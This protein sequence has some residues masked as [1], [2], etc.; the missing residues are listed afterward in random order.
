MSLSKLFKDVIKELPR[1]TVL[2]ERLMLA[3]E[4]YTALELR[5]AMQE[6]ELALSTSRINELEFE[7]SGLHLKLQEA[8]EMIRGLEAELAAVNSGN[9]SVYVC[10]HCGS[11]RLKRVGNRPHPTFGD[12][13][14][15][16]AVFSCTVCGK[17][18]AFTQ[19]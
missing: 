1:S 15:K 18:S 11:P 14:T 12:L 7:N 4:Q 16:E 8:E 19:E 3:H 9:L 5:S 10:D 17:E 13:G 6:S 2:S